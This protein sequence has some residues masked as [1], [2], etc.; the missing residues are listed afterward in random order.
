MSLRPRWG[1]GFPSLKPKR[2]CKRRDGCGA[3]HVSSPRRPI[4]AGTNSARTT[5]ASIATASAA[6]TPSCLTKKMC[7]VEKLGRARRR[8][9]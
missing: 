3:H 2:L 8:K 4:R 5:V 6:P 7:E 9:S 1:H